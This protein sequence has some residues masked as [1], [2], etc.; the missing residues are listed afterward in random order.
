[1]TPT[2]FYFYFQT[3]PIKLNR[4][5]TCD[6]QKACKQLIAK[7]PESI[8]THLNT[9][10]LCET[11]SPS[12]LALKRTSRRGAFKGLRTTVPCSEEL[13]LTNT[14]LVSSAESLRF[15]KTREKLKQICTAGSKHVLF[16][17]FS[18]FTSNFRS[19]CLV[20]VGAVL[21]QVTHTTCTSGCP[22]G[23]IILGI[24]SRF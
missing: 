11:L 22:T 3:L 6:A 20:T 7:T 21:H 19:H 9:I 15:R 5:R 2:G 10:S 16:C 13:I 17:N 24:F 12:S 4:G 23:M 1:M 18:D 14:C 8:L